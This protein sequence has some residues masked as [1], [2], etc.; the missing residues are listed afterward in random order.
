[1]S[2][3]LFQ[4]IREE[5]GLAYSVKSEMEAL[6]DTGVFLVSAGLNR[7]KAE[8][9]VKEIRKELKNIKSISQEELAKAKN[10]FQGQLALSLEDSLTQALFYGKEILLEGKIV[11]PEKIIEKIKKVKLAEVV[12]VGEKIFTANNIGEVIVG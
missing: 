8:K 10:Y 9:G 6:A 11:E 5:A 3:R 12:E 1:M 7:Q 4:R 2:S